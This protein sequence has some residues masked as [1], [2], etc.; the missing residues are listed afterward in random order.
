MDESETWLYRVSLLY[1][2]IDLHRAVYTKRKFQSAF[3]FSFIGTIEKWLHEFSHPKF[4]APFYL[5][6]IGEMV[7]DSVLS[8][9]T[10]APCAGSEFPQN[11]PPSPCPFLLD[12]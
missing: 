3:H 2:H 12:S 11:P 9:L 8:R 6:W 5:Q 1:V 10:A 7:Q 4:V